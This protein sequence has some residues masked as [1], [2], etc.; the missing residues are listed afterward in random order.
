MWKIEF[1]VEPSFGEQHWGI[2]GISPS[3]DIPASSWTLTTFPGYST[4]FSNLRCYRCYWLPGSPLE[5]WDWNIFH[6]LPISL[7]YK[8]AF[9]IRSVAASLVVTDFMTW[10]LGTCCVN[11]DNNNIVNSCVREN[12]E[13]TFGLLYWCCWLYLRFKLKKYFEQDEDDIVGDGTECGPVP[14]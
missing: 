7:R 2:P 5:N 12:I 8:L 4:Y 3:G 10:I 1:C 14:W 13:Y 9:A 11:N 6:G